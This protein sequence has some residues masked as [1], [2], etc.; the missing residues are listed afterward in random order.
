[1]LA[2]RLKEEESEENQVMTNMVIKELSEDW[3]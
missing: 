3:S 1:M 2:S